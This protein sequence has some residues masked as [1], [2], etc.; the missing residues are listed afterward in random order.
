MF[1]MK[2]IE[3]DFLHFYLDGK[4]HKLLLNRIDSPFFRQIQSLILTELSPM[5]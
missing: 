2:T 4:E 3:R 5:L 1:L